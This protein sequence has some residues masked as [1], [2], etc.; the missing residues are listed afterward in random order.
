[1]KLI[2]SSVMCVS[3]AAANAQGIP[4]VTCPVEDYPVKA[5]AAWQFPQIVGKVQVVVLRD[6]SGEQEACFDLTHGASLISLR[7]QGREML[8]GQTAGASV[9]MFSPS[10]SIDPELKHV[11]TYWAAFSP[12][13]GGLQH[14]HS[15]S[16]HRRSL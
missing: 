7:Y 2:L 3:A 13:Q 5:V 6:P 10:H 15:G 8:F 14:G 1:M 4:Q 11:S 9:S 16:G 12:D